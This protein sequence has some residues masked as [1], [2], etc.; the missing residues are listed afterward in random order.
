MRCKRVVF[1]LPLGP[2]N[3]TVSCRSTVKRDT[4][5]RKVPVGYLYLR[6]SMRI[7]CLAS[8]QGFKDLT[9][10]LIACAYPPELKEA[11]FLSEKIGF[12]W[13]ERA[14]QVTEVGVGLNLHS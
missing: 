1:P 6:F 9:R 13:S 11:D 3:A 8:L 10:G 2:I 12:L 14:S 5:N 7:T 4:S